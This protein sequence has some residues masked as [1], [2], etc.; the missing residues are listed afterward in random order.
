VELFVSPDGQQYYHF[1]VNC[2]GTLSSGKGAMGEP[3]T[4]W[5]SN[6]LARTAMDK[7]LA[8]SVTLCIPLKELAPR[9]GKGQNWLLNLNRSKP[10]DDPSSPLEA[11]WSRQGLHNYGDARGWGQL[12][13]VDVP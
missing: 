6:A 7:N 13:G 11:S 3:E 12:T 10:G 1:V 4:V 2:K 5:K 8:W 9:S